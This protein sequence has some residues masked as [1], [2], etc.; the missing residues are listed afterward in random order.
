MITNF[1]QMVEQVK[2]LTQRRRV[3]LAG[4]HDLHSLEAVLEAQKKGMVIPLL[5]G[6]RQRV[7]Q[8]LKEL[9]ASSGDFEIVDSGDEN[10]GLIAVRCV[11]EGRADFLMKGG[12]ET[13]DLLKPVLDKETGLA[14]GRTMSSF[15]IAK[16]PNY[17]KLIT[18]V[19]GGML[20]N[21]TLEE[22]RD[23]TVNSVEILHR[24]GIEDP[25][26]GVLCAIEKVNPKMPETVDAEA[27]VRMNESGELTGCKVAGPISYDLIMSKESAQIK[28][29][30]CPWCG[31]FDMILCPNIVTGNAVTKVWAY[32]AGATWAGLIL[33][34]RV[35]IVLV[36]RGSS[37]EEKYLSL[38]LAALTSGQAEI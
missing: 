8:S 30:D 2:D 6:N 16:I 20:I 12:M 7:E 32:N 27:L 10:P 36:S 35:P 23:A 5:V 17:H 29:Y 34:A 3:A 22:K 9:G 38:V 26:V 24:L 1:D 14:T 25:K 19:D 21:P 33:G 18:I 15:A 28:G 37:A 31:D 13:R 11:R 4:A